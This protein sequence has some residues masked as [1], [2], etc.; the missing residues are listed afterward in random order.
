MNNFTKELITSK[1]KMII[2]HYIKIKKKKNKI[3]KTVKEL[4]EA[5]D[6]SRKQIR[7]YY[8][9]FKRS[10][11]DELSLIP[12]KRGPVKWYWRILTKEQERIICK[13]QRQFEMKPINIWKMINIKSNILPNISPSVK[14]ISRILNR[15]PVNKKK[16]II[17]RYEKNIPW[18]LI[19][20]DWFYIPK[21]V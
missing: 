4:C 13:I 21:W 11:E 8:W 14:T 10:W 20:V 3:Y 9:R 1:W 7:K 15:Y 6:T 17:H 2:S 16:K 5:H 18:E 12:K 19:H